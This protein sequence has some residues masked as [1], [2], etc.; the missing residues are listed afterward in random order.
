MADS[1][2]RRREL[3]KEVAGFWEIMLLERKGQSVLD[4]HR[5]V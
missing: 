4:A 3:Q 5:E 1:M 2:V